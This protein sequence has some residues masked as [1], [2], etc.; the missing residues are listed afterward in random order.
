MTSILA[1]WRVKFTL[2][3][4]ISNIVVA[5]SQARDFRELWFSQH[6]ESIMSTAFAILFSSDL[7]LSV[8]YLDLGDVG[9]VHII[10]G[11]V[12]VITARCAR[13]RCL[14]SVTHVDIDKTTSP[15]SLYGI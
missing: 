9:A 7:M 12:L 1:A 2:K 6:F 11:T 10:T 13:N 8:V 14:C 5:L 4:R 3:L 15:T